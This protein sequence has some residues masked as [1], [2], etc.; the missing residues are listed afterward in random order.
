MNLQLSPI[1][2]ALITASVMLLSVY[3]AY[4]N[5]QSE[6]VKLTR[7]LYNQFYS[8]FDERRSAWFWLEKLNAEKP[9]L[10]FESL[11]RPETEA[12]N[13]MPLCK[14]LAFWLLFYRLYQTKQLDKSLARTLFGYNFFYWQRQILPLLE[15]TRE[16]DRVFPDVLEPFESVGWLLPDDCLPKAVRL[17]GKLK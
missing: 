17:N 11:W 12:E 3:I 14:V 9:S 13:F 8:I 4:R 5:R 16:H 1:F 6:R 15:S 2:A 10:S 7:D